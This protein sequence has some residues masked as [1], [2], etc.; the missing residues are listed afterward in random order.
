MAAHT[1][2]VVL[3]GLPGAGKTTLSENLVREVEKTHGSTS[4]LKVVPKHIAFDEVGGDDVQGRSSSEYDPDVWKKNRRKAHELVEA[5]VSTAPV[6]L[7]EERKLVIVDDNMHLRSMRRQMYLLARQHRTDFVI[8]YVHIPLSEALGRN[9]RRGSSSVPEHVISR[10][11]STFE[12]PSENW[13]AKTVELN[14]LESPDMEDLWEVLKAQWKEP[15]S[16]FHSPQA[17]N[18]RKVAGQ[19]SNAKSSLHQLDQTLRKELSEAV[20]AWKSENIPPEVISQRVKEANISRKKA[21]ADL[22]KMKMKSSC[23]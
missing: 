8:V 3:C 9:V 11:H 2:L 1:C 5:E 22:K 23:I 12:P 20:L 7:G 15:V 16:D 13:E 19:I 6:E 18:A 10:M 4:S 14:A 17:S 21:L